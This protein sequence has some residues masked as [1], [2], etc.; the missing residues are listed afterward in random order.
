M[1]AT[2]THGVVYDANAVSRI[3]DR[4]SNQIR[5]AADGEIVIYY[6]GWNLH[7]LSTTPAGRMHMAQHDRFGDERWQ[8]DPGYYRLLLPVP[9][10]NQ[11]NWK[12]Q[13]VHLRTNYAAWDPAAA[14]VVVTALL[15]HE[16]TKGNDLLDRGSC[17]CREE[18]G[19]GRASIGVCNGRVN[20]YSSW[21]DCRSGNLWLAVAQK[22]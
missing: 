17:R 4:R 3:L 20:V 12:D 2:Q 22:C 9:D 13:I 11:K 10:S 19:D 21:D 15:V 1:N 16:I 14:A 5:E 6:G 18:S 7:Q 8:A